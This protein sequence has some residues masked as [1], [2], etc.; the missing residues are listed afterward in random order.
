[1]NNESMPKENVSDKAFFS[2]AL[3][4]AR[5]YKFIILICP[6]LSGFLVWAMLSRAPAV[7]EATA[8]IRNAQ[9]ICLDGSYKFCSDDAI[10]NQD[11]PFQIMARLKLASSYS[12]EVVDACEAEASALAGIVVVAPVKNV[13]N[14]IE[15]RVHRATPELAYTCA[16]AIFGMINEY[17]DGLLNVY[18]KNAEDRKSQLEKEISLERISLQEMGNTNLQSFS[19]LIGRDH[20]NYL[21]QRIDNLNSALF[22]Y[23]QHRTRLIA[24]IN[25]SQ[26]PVSQRKY[27]T[28]ALGVGVG[29]LFGIFLALAV[30]RRRTFSS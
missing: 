15:L 17:Q 26:S 8:L 27:F 12:K 2:S 20:L 14:L 10:T 25:A 28:L 4:F 18:I 19:Y 11:V 30:Q 13:G 3:T 5:N 24:P 21:S 6:I 23:E 16:K 7:F 22:F 29:F 1:M 9:I